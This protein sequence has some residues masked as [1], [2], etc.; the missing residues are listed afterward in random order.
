[1]PLWRGARIALVVQHLLSDQLLVQPDLHRLVIRL[2]GQDL[3]PDV[4]PHVKRDGDLISRVRFWR[5]SPQDRAVHQV[6]VG[7][8]QGTT[9]ANGTQASPFPLLD[10]D[11]LALQDEQVVGEAVRLI[12]GRGCLEGG[13][14]LAGADPALL[15]WP[16]RSACLAHV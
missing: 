6:A 13:G 2:H 16:P 12:G 15:L 3:L 1:M 9:G 8:C 5:G 4:H 7:L 14:L 11:W 10:P